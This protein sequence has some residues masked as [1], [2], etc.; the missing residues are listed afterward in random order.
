M[1]DDLARWVFHIGQAK[2]GRLCDVVLW[3]ER[4]GGGGQQMSPEGTDG[5]NA[6]GRLE[7]GRSTQ[8]PMGGLFPQ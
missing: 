6:E 8:P 2:T 3:G 4:S 7:G 1:A 5:M